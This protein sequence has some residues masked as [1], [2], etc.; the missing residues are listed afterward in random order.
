M[1]HLSERRPRGR[2][3]V[4]DSDAHGMLALQGPAALG[5]LAPLCEGIDPLSSAPFTF[6]EARV[7]GVACTV[8]RTGY[9]GEPGVELICPATEVVALWDALIEAGAVPCGLGARDA[10]RL[11]VCYPLHGNDITQ[12]TNAIEAGLGWV[13]ATDKEFTGSDVLARTRADGP[14]RRL[15]ALR[16]DEER[17]V[18]RPGCPI[19]D[20]EGAA[21]G[22]GH[23]RDV[24]A[25][26]RSAASVWATC[27]PRWPH[28]TPRSP[29]TCAGARERRTPR[30]SRCTSRRPEPMPAAESYPDDLRYHRE[31][32]W[33]RVD[34]DTATFGVTWYAQDSLGDL[35]V[36]LP[37]EAGAEVKAGGEYGELESVKAVSGIVAPL[38]GTVIEVNQA[39]IEA[40]ELV[41]DDPYGQGWLIRVQLSDPRELDDLLDAAAYAAHVAGL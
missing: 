37:P 32:D 17:A 9:T 7:A 10:L 41:N 31:H 27:R 8:A 25:H 34:G 26:A 1:A 22:N 29:W 28:P 6:A 24:L 4:D 30:A 14:Q 15:V 11:E 21:V 16:M 38:S 39:V 35:V 40:P 13:C 23:E 12:E 20:G 18:P 3:L 33:A 19:L 2:T 36:Y 5:L